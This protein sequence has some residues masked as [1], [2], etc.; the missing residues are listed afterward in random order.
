MKSLKEY[1]FE[2]AK[3]EKEFVF[4]F[5]GLENGE[6]TVKS[7]ASVYGCTANEE[8]Q[9]V[10]ITVTK[11]NANKLETA[12]DILQQ[13]AQGIRNSTKRASDEQYA[14][15]TKSFENKV[16]EFNFFELKIC[17]NRIL[18]IS[19]SKI[20]LRSCSNLLIGINPRSLPLR[21]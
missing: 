7:M 11:D 8:K 18:S 19:I 17:S 9:E 1:L 10:S 5:K 6:E 2:A 13:F 21:N 12:K 16:N 15:K 3:E 4:S 14:Q 20:Y